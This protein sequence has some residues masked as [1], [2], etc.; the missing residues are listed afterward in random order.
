MELRGLQPVQR[1]EA[2]RIDP[3]LSR[4]CGLGEERERR[5]ARDV[6]VQRVRIAA[7]RSARELDVGDLVAERSSDETCERPAVGQPR[8]EH[9]QARI[10]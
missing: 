5:L 3:V 1:A 8:H 10:H 2:Q 7:L 9:R 4:T 6:E